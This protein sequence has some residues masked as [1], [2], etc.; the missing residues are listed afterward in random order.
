MMVPDAKDLSS[1][2]MQAAG[3]CKQL[4]GLHTANVNC[5]AVQQG[6]LAYW[7]ATQS[8]AAAA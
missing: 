5:P 6:R 1:Y 8:L 2:T 4:T 7:G 3:V